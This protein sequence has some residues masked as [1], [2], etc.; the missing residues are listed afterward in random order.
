MDESH[1]VIIGVVAEAAA[2]QQTAC[3]LADR[4]LLGNIDWLTNELLPA[5]R[6]YR[7][8][9]FGTDFLAW[10]NVR[11]QARALGIKLHGHFGGEPGAPDAFV[12]REA[13]AVFVTLRPAAVVLIRDTDNQPERRRGLEQARQYKHWPF[14]VILGVAHAKRECWVL[15]GFEPAGPEE[16]TL[17][18]NV[19]TE[20]GFDPCTKSEQLTAKAPDAHRQ[21]KRVLSLLTGEN[22]D[23]QKLCVQ[24]TE[25]PI[26]K[27]RGK[28]NG[29]KDYLKEVESILVPLVQQPADR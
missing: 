24:Q 25:I 17:L 13:L 18:S 29:L 3:I 21:A 28:K 15:C 2:D 9:D 12:A 6:V 11:D 4:V 7:G 23:R 5:N 8:A 22:L 20:L 10:K 26:L 27:E 19:Q 16:A 1:E 14:K